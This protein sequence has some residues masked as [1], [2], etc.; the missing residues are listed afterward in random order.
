MSGAA[1]QVLA[2]LTRWRQPGPEPLVVAIDGHG[3]AGK[4]TIA[5]AVAARSGAEVIAMDSFFH[6]AAPD[7]DP[8]PMA[9]YYDWAALRR[10]ALGPAIARLRAQPGSGFILLEGVS[11]GAPALADLVGRSVLVVTPEPVRLER[12]HNRISAE[13]WDE[14]WLEAERAYFATRPPASF[15]LVVC[16]DTEA[17]RKGGCARGGSA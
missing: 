4:T 12:L 2:A 1:E 14:E 7:H 5:H 15:D 10:K 3:A 17:Q 16:G 11:S 8:R 9:Q 6:A 13:E